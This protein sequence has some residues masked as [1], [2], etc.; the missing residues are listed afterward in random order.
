MCHA[1]TSS[2]KN[3]LSTDRHS[4]LIVKK[5]VFEKEN[6]CIG[7]HIYCKGGKRVICE[8]NIFDG[9]DCW[10]QDDIYFETSI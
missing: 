6:G 8:D 3:T 9:K 7:K 5:C 4:T 1:I 10:C 2:E